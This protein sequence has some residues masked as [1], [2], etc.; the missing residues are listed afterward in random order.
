MENSSSNSGEV[1]SAACFICFNLVPRNTLEKCYACETW[2]CPNCLHLCEE[3]IEDGY[4]GVNLCKYCLTDEE[5]MVE[6]AL[7]L[8]QER[9]QDGEQDGQIPK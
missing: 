5:E 7:R 4:K 2:S 3:I 6:E 9:F 8:K 1:D